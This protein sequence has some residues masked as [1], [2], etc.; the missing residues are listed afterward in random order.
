MVRYIILL[1]GTVLA[2]L[3]IIQLR[4]GSRYEDLVRHLDGT[5]FPLNSLYLVGFAWCEVPLLRFHGKKA[6]RLKRQAA[7]LYEEKYAEYYANLAW[8]Q[9]IT[10][11]HL[12]LTGTFLLAGLFYYNCRFFLFVGGFLTFLAG[13]YSLTNM[14]DQIT[15]RREACEAQLAE[16]VSTMAI[17]LNTGM[18]L[19]EVWGL[20]SRHGKG[21]LYDLMRKTNDS[22][23]SGIPEKE[24]LY[25]FAQE[26]DSLEIRKF[27]SAMLQS[28]EKGGSELSF[29][30]QQ[31]SSELWHIR[32][33]H[34][35][36]NGEKAATKL[37][38]PIMLIFVGIIIIVMT[39]AFSGSL[40]HS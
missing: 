31:Q 3:F 37:L 33:Q 16:M 1:V 25:Q 12:F 22:I 11:V 35:L 18:V 36:Q 38:A 26:S 23:N 13:G 2:V 27:T 21:D 17:L 6:V 9:A 20:V 40:F 39:A 10:G 4:R 8:A 34:M 7:L 5:K 32:R 19:R 29:F 30:M 15:R 14:K 28:M 24:A